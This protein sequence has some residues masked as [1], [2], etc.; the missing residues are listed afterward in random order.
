MN[1]QNFRRKTLNA[2]FSNIFGEGAPSFF[3]G[4][5]KSQQSSQ[6]PPQQQQQQQP[7]QQSTTP[8]QVVPGQTVNGLPEG[9]NQPEAALEKGGASPLD[10]Y[11]KMF[12]NDNANKGGDTTDPNSPAAKA[13]AQQSRSVFDA[14]L[15]DFQ[16][17]TQN[18]NYVPEFDDEL[19]SS[20][21]RGDKQSLSK[22]LNQVAQNAVASSVFMASRVSQQGFNQNLDKFKGELPAMQ[23]SQQLDSLF[24]GK[25]N[26]L[27]NPAVQPLVKSATKMF[28][29]QYP[30]ASPDEIKAYV[31]EY[32]KDVAG[33]FNQSQQQ[34]QKHEQSGGFNMASLFDSLN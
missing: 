25:D 7:P 4:G 12:Q 33:V 20:A 18:Q 24:T 32:M 5:Q 2:S 21:L 11:A 22:L 30:Q 13:A 6:Q 15:E 14:G 17:I 28:A 26:V 27:S 34:P 16:K 19:M 10:K 31:Q 9:A 23:R 8:S 1:L 3:G 29:E